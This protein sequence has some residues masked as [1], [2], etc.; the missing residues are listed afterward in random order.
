MRQ[1]QIEP[2]KTEAKIF[3]TI[4][5]LSFNNDITKAKAGN[6]AAI[7]RVRKTLLVIQKDCKIARQQF[8][9]LTKL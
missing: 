2:I 9:N 8:Q 6:K 5:D 3:Q 1:L 4:M 7:R